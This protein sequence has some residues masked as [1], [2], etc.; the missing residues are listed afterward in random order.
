MLEHFE[1]PASQRSHW[2]VIRHSSLQD[3]P[4]S[5]NQV[6]LCAVSCAPTA[7]DPEIVAF[8]LSWGAS[9]T[10]LPA[11]ASATTRAASSR[12]NE[13]GSMKETP[14]AQRVPLPPGG[15][16]GELRFVIG[17]SAG[18]GVC[19]RPSAHGRRTGSPSR[20]RSGPPRR[21]CAPRCRRTCGRRRSR[22]T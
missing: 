15:G 7:A 2:Y 22:G 6:P 12:R 20:S 4:L 18:A 14:L 9:A 11:V 16:R 10:A 17:I 13:R 8:V 1:P 21:P 5:Y 19:L 3:V